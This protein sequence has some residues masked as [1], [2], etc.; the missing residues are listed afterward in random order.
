MD[1]TVENYIPQTTD[2]V[3]TPTYYCDQLTGSDRFHEC[4]AGL[5]GWTQIDTNEYQWN[6]S[7]DEWET[8]EGCTG[9]IHHSFA[10]FEIAANGRKALL[11]GREEEDGDI[12]A[13]GN[14]LLSREYEVEVASIMQ[15]AT[16]TLTF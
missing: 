11:G 14:I 9:E 15:A 10:S 8:S 6:T 3:S 7:C 16:R 13:C 1:E 2:L 12:R 5:P 4:D